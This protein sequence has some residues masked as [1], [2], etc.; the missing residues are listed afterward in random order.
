VRSLVTFAVMP[1]VV[2]DLEDD[3]AVRAFVGSHVVGGLA[4]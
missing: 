4:H 1:S 3:R 2:I